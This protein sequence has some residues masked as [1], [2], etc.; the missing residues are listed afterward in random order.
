MRLTVNYSAA[1]KFVRKD[2]LDLAKI[3]HEQKC[4]MP[5]LPDYCNSKNIVFC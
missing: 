2:F 3:M 5:V 4:V 1:F